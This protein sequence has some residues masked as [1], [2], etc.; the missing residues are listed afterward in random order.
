MPHVFSNRRRILNLTANKKELRSQFRW[1]TINAIAYKIG[2][3]LFVVGS[4]FLFPSQAEYAHIGGWLFLAAS[5][6]YLVV[7][8]HD[9]AEIR[10]F[11]K[12]HNSHSGDELLEYIAGI[13]YLMGTLSFVFGR[14]CSFP[15]IAWY[16][17]SA[18]L[19]IAGSL[20]FVLGA[21]VNV[22]LV[23]K[24]ES[25]QLLQLMNLTSI[26]FIIGSVLYALASV[27]YLLAFESANDHLLVKNFLAWQYMI[28]SLLFMLG[29][30][31][32]YWRAYILV[33]RKIEKQECIG[34]ERDF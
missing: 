6:T 7:N 31:S 29:G 24:A 33:Q 10:R 12:S 20:L 15:S 13:S 11:W 1:E 18:W 25:V 2:G 9:L 22:Y 23:V 30:M 34:A 19:F 4:Y 21:G 3:L 5:L 26:S 27:P 28:G 16:D 32:N 14:L 17:T 8:V